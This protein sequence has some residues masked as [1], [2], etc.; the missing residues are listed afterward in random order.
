MRKD[1]NLKKEIML[2]LF[3]FWIDFRYAWQKCKPLLDFELQAYDLGFM[4]S[5]ANIEIVNDLYN[6]L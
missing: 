3:Y 2:Q 4:I 5:L 6:E 1:H